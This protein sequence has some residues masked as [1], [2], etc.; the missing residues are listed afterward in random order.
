MF[1]PGL[2]GRK[3][4]IP[5]GKTGSFNV[6][7]KHK[8]TPCGIC[9]VNIQRDSKNENALF[10]TKYR[11]FDKRGVFDLRNKLAM[12][13]VLSEIMEKSCLLEKT[14]IKCGTEERKSFQCFYILGFILH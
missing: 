2:A 14:R 4:G 10:D 12:K 1:R 3:R 13:R 5:Q 11:L 6:V 9:L 7:L 8:A